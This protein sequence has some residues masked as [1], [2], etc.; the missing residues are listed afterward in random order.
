MFSGPEYKYLNKLYIGIVSDNKKD[1]IIKYSF[2]INPLSYISGSAEC[3][4][5]DI[6]RG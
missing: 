4:G 5:L 6:I 1:Q 3:E 2:Q